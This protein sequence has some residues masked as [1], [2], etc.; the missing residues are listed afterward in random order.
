M[1][2]LA[3]GDRPDPGLWDY[4]NPQKVKDVDLIISCG[5]LKP[6]YL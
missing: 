6:E 3:I 5:E 4:Y 1:K 2:I